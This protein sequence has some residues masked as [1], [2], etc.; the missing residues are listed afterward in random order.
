MGNLN[1]EIRSSQATISYGVGSVYNILGESFVLCDTKIWTSSSYNARGSRVKAKRLVESISENGYKVDELFKPVDMEEAREVFYQPPAK[2]L[3]YQRFPQWLFCSS[4]RQMFCWDWAR[5][6]ENSGD[7]PTCPDCGDRHKLTPMRFILICEDGHMGDVPWDR[8][9]HSEPQGQRQKTC[10]EDERLKFIIREG[11]GGGFSSM[12]VK[13]EACGAFRSLEGIMGENA[14][15]QTGYSCPG[16]QP[17]QIPSE[18]EDCESSTHVVQRGAGSVYYPSS[19]SAITIPPESDRGIGGDD[20]EK[21]VRNH[22]NYDLWDPDDQV[23]AEAVAEK[24]AD[25]LGE[26]VKDVMEALR[27]D[28]ENPERTGE[29][30]RVQEWGALT[31]THTPQQPEAQFIN[32]ELQ[33]VPSG[34]NSPVLRA[35]DPLI[36]K[37]MAVRKL[38]EVRAL[39]G[40]HR[41]KPGDAGDGK[42]RLTRPDLG[43]ELNWLPATEVFGEGVFLTLN[44][45]RLQ[46]WE[47]TEAVRARVDKL[48]DH[49]QDTIY[50]TILPD[51]SP[52]FV[53]LHTLAHLL[54][55]RL[56]FSCGYSS[57]SLRERIYA[58]IP[59]TNE[60]TRAG[61]L[62]Y[63]AAGDMEGTLGGLVRQAEP[64]RLGSNL[65]SALYDARSCSSDPVCFE[66]R[67][68]G[69]RGLNL[70][71]C[72]GCTLAAETSCQVHNL[73]L[74]R[75]LLIGK[76]E[77]T[78]FFEEVLDHAISSAAGTE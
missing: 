14:L 23:L 74:D 39:L 40:F 13:C 61:I 4:C 48:S 35:L 42:D 2:G 37:V 49:K 75:V 67:G 28:D 11:Y 36:D 44:E 59:E 70:A 19:A 66:S 54:I 43:K 31:Q 27:E 8:W 3:P 65:I 29:D 73:L 16:K 51:S 12:I 33:L 64:P 9:A 47:N 18:R 20:L 58:E 41:Y 25:S 52:R 57:A 62:I 34:E 10:R 53:L 77:V 21:R 5:E 26:S 45:D 32:E 68:Q 76:E 63:T 46:E 22:P 17:W 1:R 6:R 30:L 60:R 38:R 71:A 69:I 78:G 56:A 7:R 55:K 24:I 50:E 15:A 72:H